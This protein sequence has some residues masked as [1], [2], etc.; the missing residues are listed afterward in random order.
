MR[1]LT[2]A[3]IGNRYVP[4]DSCQVFRAGVTDRAH[5]SLLEIKQ[6]TGNMI[7]QR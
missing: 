7:C 6:P 4:V 1:A 2:I 5:F 3:D